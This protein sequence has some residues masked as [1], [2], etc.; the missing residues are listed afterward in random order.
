MRDSARRHSVGTKT[1]GCIPVPSPPARTTTRWR[2][3]VKSVCDKIG[4]LSLLV[5]AF[6]VL[7]VIAVCLWV[8]DPTGKIIYKQRRS[9]LGKKPFVIYKFRT[10][11]SGSDAPLRQAT[12]DD[13]RITPFGKLLRANSLDEL[14][15]LINVIRGEMSLVGPRP[16]AIPHDQ[17]YRR[18]IDRYD[19]RYAVRPGMTGWAQIH[20]CR[21]ETS[22]LRSMER[23][24]SLDLEYVD[25]WS[26][27]LD[28]KILMRTMVTVLHDTNAH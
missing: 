3:A 6:P 14:P 2:T 5:V 23:R 4:A 26:L 22:T 11:K 17:F 15:Q 12:R 9:G 7:L 27:T 24:V 19:Q 10:M 25:R 13:P 20:G 21:G 16:H 8:E 28:L 1:F 18:L